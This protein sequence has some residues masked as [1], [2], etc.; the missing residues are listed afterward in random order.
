MP[1]ALRTAWLARSTRQHANRLYSTAPADTPRTPPMMQKL[2][3]DLKTAMRAR[4]APRLTALRSIMSENLN[5]SKTSSPIQ[6]D[7]QL[8]SLIRKLRRSTEEAV[9]EAKAAGRDDLVEK[10]SG[11]A[12]LYDE[13][14]AGSGIQIVAGDE[15][16]TMVREVVEQCKTAGTAPKLLVREAMAR[17]TQMAEGKDVDRKEAAKI[18]KE[19]TT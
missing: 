19:Y 4:D 12:Q 18:L 13:Y 6:T 8:V 15:L 17:I 3:A 9:G 16:K 10:E 5:A 7:L 14:I 11:Q 2:R 1:T